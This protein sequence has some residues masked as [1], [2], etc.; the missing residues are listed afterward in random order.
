MCVL[1]Y[2]IIASLQGGHRLTHHLGLTHILVQLAGLGWQVG[3]I[4]FQ[5]CSGGDLEEV[6]D[7]GELQLPLTWGEEMDKEQSTEVMADCGVQRQDHAP[8]TLR[9]MER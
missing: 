5:W 2:C 1:P 9:C 3:T 7:L 4:G 8:E 6:E